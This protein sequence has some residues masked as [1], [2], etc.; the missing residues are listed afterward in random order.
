MFARGA[1]SA[2][3]DYD[4]M[5]FMEN[6]RKNQILTAA[7]DGWGSEGQ[8]VCHVDGRAVFVPRAIPGEL[9]E[10]RIVK[11]SAGAVYARG[12]RLLQPSPAR[13]ESDCPHFGKCGGC[14]T[15][16]MRY[17]EELRFKLDRVNAALKHICKQSL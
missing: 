14:D 7:I 2:E 12:E 17:E 3:R 10:I 9:W 1:L 5:L 11:L 15:R 6:L 16:H 8:G 4:N 13:V